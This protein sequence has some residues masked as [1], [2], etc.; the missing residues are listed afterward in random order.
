MICIVFFRYDGRWDFEYINKKLNNEI[1]Q[2]M[3]MDVFVF[4][5]DFLMCRMLFNT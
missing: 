3:E 5:M 1:N 4:F 2:I